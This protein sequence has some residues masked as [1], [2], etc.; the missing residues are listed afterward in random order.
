MHVKKRS[1]QNM[2]YE[3]HVPLNM[4]LGMQPNLSLLRKRSV[5]LQNAS[6]N[7]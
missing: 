7:P 3:N 4:R 5:F 2:L 6:G 1:F